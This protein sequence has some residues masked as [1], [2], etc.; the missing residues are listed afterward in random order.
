[1]KPRS[2]LTFDSQTRYDIASGRFNLAQHSLTLQPDS[3]WS[4]TVGHL[5]LREGTLPGIGDNLLSSVFFYRLNENW[6]TRMAHYFDARAGNLQEQDYSIYRDLRSW[7]VALTFRV[8][9]NPTGPQD[10][11]VAFTFSLKAFPRFGLGD[12]NLRPYTLFGG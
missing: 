2:W 10:Y 5:F 11:T 8:R 9:D 3:T 1:M 7:T 6:G 12:D 4:W